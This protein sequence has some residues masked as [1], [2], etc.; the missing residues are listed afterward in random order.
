MPG[1]VPKNPAIFHIT[2]LAN[3]ASIVEHGC[4]WSDAQRIARGLVSTSIGHQHI[5]QRRLKRQVLTAFGGNLGDYVPFNFCSRSV[6]LYVVGKGHQD[7]SGGEEEILH[8][9]S[10]VNRAIGLGR[11]WAFT[12]QHADLAYASFYSSRD[13]LREVDWDVMPRTYWSADDVKA[14]R[15]AEFLVHDHFSWSGVEQ[16][17]VKTSAVAARVRAL[18]TGG[19]APRIVVQPSWYY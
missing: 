18:L 15:Q 5:K 12:N 19:H 8:L 2:A 11:P 17:G 10:S 14:R 9:V 7:Y 1:A 13:D 6:M 16:I 4:L 3:L